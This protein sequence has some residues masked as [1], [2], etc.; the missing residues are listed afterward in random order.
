MNDDDLRILSEREVSRIG[1]PMAYKGYY[2][3]ILAIVISV[4]AGIRKASLSKEIYSSIADMNAVTK[5]SV[6]KAIRDVLTRAWMEGSGELRSMR[7]GRSGT[8][9]NGEVIA[10][11]TSRIRLETAPVI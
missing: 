2:Y 9:T 11:I 10:Y 8:P 5:G 3:L 6:E 1:V 7:P 4:R